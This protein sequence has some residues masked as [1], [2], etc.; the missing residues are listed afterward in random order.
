MISKVQNG[1]EHVNISESSPVIKPEPVQ[2]LIESTPS[3]DD[4]KSPTGVRNMQESTLDK[5]RKFYLCFIH[6]VLIDF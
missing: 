2:L 5:E 4:I 3:V 1:I 6:G